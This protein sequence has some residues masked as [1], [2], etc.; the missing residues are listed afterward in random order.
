MTKIHT[1]TPSELRRIAEAKEKKAASKTGAA[2]HALMQAA[3]ALRSEADEME[4][5]T[6][7]LN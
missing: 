5:V 4:G 3:Q 1:S 7:C 6:E 2:Y